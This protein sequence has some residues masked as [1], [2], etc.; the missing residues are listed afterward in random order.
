MMD[1]AKRR[2]DL[3]PQR[4]SGDTVGAVRLL[5]WLVDCIDHTARSVWDKPARH[6][7]TFSRADLVFDRERNIEYQLALLATDV[8]RRCGPVTPIQ[9]F[10]LIRSFD[11]TIPAQGG[12]MSYD[13][14]VGV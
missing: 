2:F 4:F 13:F 6:D 1:R 9:A 11:A 8:R 5:K 10:D 3:R 14:R 7:G 12:G